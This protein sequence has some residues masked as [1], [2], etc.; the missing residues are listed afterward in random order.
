[1]KVV[2][3]RGVA[4]HNVE[5]VLKLANWFRAAMPDVVDDHLF[6]LETHIR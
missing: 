5:Y 3:S 1:M 4:G 6:T 2:N